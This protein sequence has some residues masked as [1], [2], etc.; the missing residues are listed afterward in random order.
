MT[1]GL[2]HPKYAFKD[3]KAY[4]LGHTEGGSMSYVEDARLTLEEELGDEY[5]CE[6]EL[7]DLYTLLV[8]IKGED[9]TLEDVHDAWSVWTH[10][11]RPEHPSLVPFDLLTKEIQDYDEPYAEAIRKASSA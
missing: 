1:F 2:R 10:R 9:C 4:W 6:P 7:V 8:L 5:S 3:E 11:S